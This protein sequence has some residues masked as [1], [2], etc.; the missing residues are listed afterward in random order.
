[1][2]SYERQPNKTQWLFEQQYLFFWFN[3]I[4]NIWNN[5]CIQCNKI[6][7]RDLVIFRHFIPLK[8][9]EHISF[10]GDEMSHVQLIL[11]VWAKVNLC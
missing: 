7:I 9:C 10:K 4:E 6:Y 11:F 8:L 2:K 5:V 3:I 1:M